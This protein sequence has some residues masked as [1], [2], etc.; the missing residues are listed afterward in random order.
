MSVCMYE[1]WCWFSVE[2]L[3][4]SLVSMFITYSIHLSI[5]SFNGI[6]FFLFI[7][8]V[9]SWRIFFSKAEIN[10]TLYKAV[11]LRWSAASACNFRVVTCP[12]S[13][14]TARRSMWGISV[15]W[16]LAT[17]TIIMGLF[18]VV[19]SLCRNFTRWWLHWRTDCQWTSAVFHHHQVKV[20]NALPFCFSRE[21]T[22]YC[23][24]PISNVDVQWLPE[25]CI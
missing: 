13:C 19:R 22:N 8:N 9:F 11:C 10:W 1:C 18:L 21:E 5:K 7:R 2:R 25:K 16:A 12:F 6:Y 4:V 14:L 24:W 20:K 23:S 3:N 17:M 15:I